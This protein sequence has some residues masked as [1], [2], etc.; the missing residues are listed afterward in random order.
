MR[1]LGIDFGE[2]RIGLALS[3]EPGT[4]AFPYDTVHDISA[5]RKVVAAKGVGQIIVGLPHSL[6]GRKTAET[7]AVEGFVAELRKAVQLPVELEDEMFTTKIARRA[8]PRGK[9]DASAAALILQS[10]L[11]KQAKQVK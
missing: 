8:S 6:A 10:Y 11:D 7:R 3:D 1:S 2:K 9:A 5:I 4:L